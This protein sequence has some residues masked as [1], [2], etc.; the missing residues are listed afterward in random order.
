MLAYPLYLKMV[1]RGCG[2]ITICILSLMM[3]GCDNCEYMP[4]KHTHYVIRTQPHWQYLFKNIPPRNPLPIFGWCCRQVKYRFRD[5]YFMN[6][7]TQKTHHML[8]DHRP[9]RG[10]S[11]FEFFSCIYPKWFDYYIRL[12][13]L[14]FFLVAGMVLICRAHTIAAGDLMLIMWFAFDSMILLW[15]CAVTTSNSLH[16]LYSFRMFL[17]R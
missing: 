3:S 10:I 16:D 14:L 17:V 5:I 1:K 7:P 11:L 8:S 12:C 9:Y 2:R 6:Y 4:H 13:I 15:W